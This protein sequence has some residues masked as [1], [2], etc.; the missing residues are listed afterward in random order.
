MNDI[1]DIIQIYELAKNFMRIRGNQAQWN[2]GYPGET[3]IV[4]DIK[5]KNLFV[6]IDHDN[7]IV[8]VFAFIIGEDPT[9]ASI[10]G[11]WIN[12]EPYG[13][14]H[15]I[16][17]NGK[18]S[19]LFD[20]CTDFCLKKINNLRIDTHVDNL[21]MLNALARNNFVKCG[22]II[23]ADGTPREAYQFCKQQ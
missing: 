10:D 15:R 1:P 16:A 14:I 20:E 9:Y 18:H 2:N 12:E 21:P 17:T 7:D 19:R 3:D 13:T 8:C 5:R 4:S 11:N 22:V 6:G 23:C